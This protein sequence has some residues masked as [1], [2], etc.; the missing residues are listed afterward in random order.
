MNKRDIM[1]ELK[2]SLY[3]DYSQQ[4]ASLFKGDTAARHSYAA[5]AASKVQFAQAI[6]G[7]Q[8]HHQINALADTVERKAASDAAA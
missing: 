6:L 5:I 4:W 1:A 2:T 3:Y 8:Y 7:R